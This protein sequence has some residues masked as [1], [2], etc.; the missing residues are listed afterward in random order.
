MKTYE[1]KDYDSQMKEIPDYA[2]DDR[3]RR[4]AEAREAEKIEE[5]FREEILEKQERGR[6]ITAWV[7]GIVAILCIGFIIAWVVGRNEANRDQVAVRYVQPVKRV[8]VRHVKAPTETARI[9]YYAAANTPRSGS[10]DDDRIEREARQVIHGDF[11][12]NPGRKAKLGADYAAVQAR[13]N[14]LLA[15]N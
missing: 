4:L 6:R 7:L 9:K 5:D 2:E 13:V 12:V 8:Y 10:A 3:Q 15:H 14:Q 11:G 1:D